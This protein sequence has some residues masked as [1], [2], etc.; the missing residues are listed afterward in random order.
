MAANRKTTGPRT[1]CHPFLLPAEEVARQLG[2]NIETGW[3]YA[4]VKEIQAEHPPNELETG[5]GISW[6]KILLK[7]CSNAMMLVWFSH[8]LPI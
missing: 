2:V 3:S 6:W 1:E 5:G 7:Q 8:S 4:R